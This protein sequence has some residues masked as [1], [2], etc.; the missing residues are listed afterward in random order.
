MYCVCTLSY[1]SSVGLCFCSQSARGRS[2]KDPVTPCSTW[3]FLSVSAW[4]II[5]TIPDNRWRHSCQSSPTAESQQPINTRTD[6]AFMCCQEDYP[7]T[8]EFNI[9]SVLCSSAFVVVAKWKMTETQFIITCYFGKT[10]LDMLIHL[11]YHYFCKLLSNLVLV[12]LKL[13]NLFW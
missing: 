4:G 9:T 12:V 1:C 2:L 10:V 11:I 3:I 5:S 8:C 6:G 7:F 13:W